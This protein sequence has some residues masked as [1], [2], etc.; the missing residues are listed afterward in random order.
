MIFEQLEFAQDNL[1]QPVA[2][3]SLTTDN[4]LT[5]WVAGLPTVDDGYGLT[6]AFIVTAAGALTESSN[7]N[8]P[9]P[10]NFPY[11]EVA[12][13]FVASIDMSPDNG[14]L[15][16]TF[17]PSAVNSEVCTCCCTPLSARTIVWR[18]SRPYAM[19][20]ARTQRSHTAALE[21][22]SDTV[23]AERGW[24]LLLT[25]VVQCL[26]QLTGRSRFLGSGPC[27]RLSDKRLATFRMHTLEAF[28]SWLPRSIASSLEHPHMTRWPGCR[29]HETGSAL[30]CQ[31]LSPW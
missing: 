14:R 1:H 4:K 25:D 28:T 24:Q 20:Q 8:F 15:Y 3:A 31:L 6:Y 17:A 22:R 2:V 23:Y 18:P 13:V 16:M 26:S 9:A 30:A 11:S 19:C 7:L 29:P 12:G 10:P 21:A 27:G 5:L